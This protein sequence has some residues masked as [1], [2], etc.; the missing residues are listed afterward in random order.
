MDVGFV[1]RTWDMEVL[2]G[3]VWEELE[4]R[5]WELRGEISDEYVVHMKVGLRDWVE[6][7]RGMGGFVG[8]SCVLADE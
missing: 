7:A 8:V 2:Y 1:D 6:G 3:R 4:V 5:G